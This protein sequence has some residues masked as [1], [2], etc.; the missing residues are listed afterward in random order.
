[1]KKIYALLL[2]VMMFACACGNN[3]DTVTSDENVSADNEQVTDNNENTLTAIPVRISQETVDVEGFDREFNI[4][5]LADS[6]ISLCDDRDKELMEKAMSRS[7]MFAAEGIEAWD[8]FDAM[9][10]DA[11]N[12]GNDI[13]ILGGDIIDSAM[14]ASIDHVSEQLKTLSIPY[15]YSMGNHDFEYGTEY[16]SPAAYEEYLPR[17]ND[18]HG[19][20]SYQVKEYDDLIIFAADDDNSQIDAPI[21]EAY[22]KEAAKGKPI[23]LIVH[24]PIEPVTGDDSLT[25]KCK[26][27]W[28]PSADDK[29]RVTMGV[30]G[31]YPNDTTREFLD[32]VLADD[33]PVVLVLAGHIHFYH[34]DMLNDKTVQ[35]VTG[36]AF[37]GDALRVTLK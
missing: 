15:M 37:E 13:V 25:E 22:K 9:I 6:H 29:S 21:L 16:F 24:V 34:K 31:C 8:R 10:T 11:K 28:G 26:E 36:A 23:V 1:M 3:T 5:F 17:L 12:G 19:S 32:L 7:P 35:I 14:Y 30:N 20:E 2:A 4:F 33:S 18:I 27:V